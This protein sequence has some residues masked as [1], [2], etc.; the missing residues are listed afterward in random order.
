MAATFFVFYYDG[1]CHNILPRKTAANFFLYVSIQMFVSAEFIGHTKVKY[2]D[3]IVTLK[4]NILI[5]N[6]RRSIMNEKRSEL[7]TW[8]NTF[9]C[10]IKL[11]DDQH[12]EL[13]TMVN[14]MFL[15]VTGS[16]ETEHEYFT[17]VIQR[18]VD[19][20]KLHFSTEEK[21]MKAARYEGYPKHK[22]IHDSF[23]FN[24]LETIEDFKSGKRMSLYNFTKYLK[25]WI[26]SHIAIMDRQYFGYLNQIA[27]SRDNENF[28][29]TPTVMSTH[30]I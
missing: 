17:G 26:F 16:E 30:I 24:I 8:S 23:I 2:L 7:I 1:C 27:V 6:D 4:L 15:H 3:L 25:D 13:V 21:I 20:V 9:S 28:S 29:V 14:E 12:K 19:Y 10:G 22:H 18:V 11:I 5:C